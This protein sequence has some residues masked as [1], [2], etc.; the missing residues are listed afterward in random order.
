MIA[1]LSRI[2]PMLILLAAI[3][4]VVYLVVAYRQS[5]NRAKEVLIKI[6]IVLTSVISGFFMLASLYALLENN[7]AVFDLAFSFMATGVI[8][9]AV[10]L[11]CRMVFLRH[12]P[13]YR[14]KPMKAKR[15]RRHR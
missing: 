13:E 11:V 6:F 2:V 14:K 9:L 4:L 12:H 7:V 3:A 15:L 10:T 5:P 8:G 1:R